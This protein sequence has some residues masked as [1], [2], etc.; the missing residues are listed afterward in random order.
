VIDVETDFHPTI[1]ITTDRN[2]LLF[3][4]LLLSLIASSTSNIIKPLDTDLKFHS[5]CES[6]GINATRV[7]LAT[8]P[9]SVAGRGVFA[10]DHLSK[11]DTAVTIPGHCVFT[12]KI[13][14]QYFPTTANDLRRRSKRNRGLIGR[15]FRRHPRV[16]PEDVWQAELTAYAMAAVESDHPWA[17]W[18][19][20]WNRDDPVFRLYEDGVLSSDHGSISKAV[21]ELH[22]MLPELHK[23]HI[24]AAVQ[25]RLQRF[26][27]QEKIFFKQNETAINNRYRASIARMYSMIGSRALDLGDDIVG[28]VPMYDMV[29]HS[30]DPNLGFYFNGEYF[31]LF[32]LRDISEGEELFLC[33]N[34]LED[35]KNQ[36]WNEMN[37]LWML[38]QWGIPTSTQ[39]AINQL[40]ALQKKRQ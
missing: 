25:I 28:V 22:M 33:Y 24:E 26:E 5:W 8:T 20:Q 32:A 14:S 17:F 36:G 18:I 31:E 10:L 3:N 12:P 15:L 35:I 29:N 38:I 30:L 40:D 21:D 7:Q 1:K 37:S 2:M 39:D 19:N 9:R 13:A 11:G 4:K 16:N 27:S 23:L 34:E 6:I